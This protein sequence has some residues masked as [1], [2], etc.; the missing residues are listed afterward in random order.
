M[1]LL[2][3]VGW[4]DVATKRDLDHLSEHMDLKFGQS[5]ERVKTDAGSKGRRPSS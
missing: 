1:E 2:P 3:P 4:A 5:D